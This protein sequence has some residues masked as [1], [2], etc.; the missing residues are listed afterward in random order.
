MPRWSSDFRER[1]KGGFVG[2]I[3]PVEGAKRKGTASLEAIPLRESVFQNG[4]MMGVGGSCGNR[5]MPE[6]VRFKVLGSIGV[7]GRREILEQDEQDYSGGFI[8]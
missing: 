3:A 1:T 4:A 2:V 7:S 5:G 6:K 8:F